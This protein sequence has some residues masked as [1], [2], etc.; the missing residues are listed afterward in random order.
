LRLSSTERTIT[1]IWMRK[2][3]SKRVAPR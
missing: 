2:L 3:F 1:G